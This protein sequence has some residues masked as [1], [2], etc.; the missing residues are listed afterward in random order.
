MTGRAFD[1]GG[2]VEY[3]WAGDFLE[4][5]AK[6]RAEHNISPFADLFEENAILQPDPFEP[7]LTG[8]N[9]IRAYLL[10]CADREADVELT[11]E[12]HWVAGST[13]LAAWHASFVGRP[14]RGHIR[15]AGFLTADIRAERCVRLRIWAV[16]KKDR[17]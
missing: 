13:I 11:F 16:E 5:Y 14:D 4:G 2:P 8:T 3:A 7:P 6:A 10:Q 1:P 9:E 12:R 17:G 15:E